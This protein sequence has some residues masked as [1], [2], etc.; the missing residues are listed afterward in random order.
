MLRR[1]GGGS[2]LVAHVRGRG[3]WVEFGQMS[4]VKALRLTLRRSV[5]HAKTKQVPEQVQHR[6]PGNGLLC[7]RFYPEERY[8]GQSK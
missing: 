5:C 8:L 3:S 4:R 2:L 1:Y 7:L 6:H